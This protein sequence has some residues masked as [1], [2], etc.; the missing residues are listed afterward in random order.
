MNCS[1]HQPCRPPAP[2]MTWESALHLHLGAWGQPP[3][4]ESGCPSGCYLG[5]SRVGGTTFMLQDMEEGQEAAGCHKRRFSG[6]GGGSCGISCHAP[7]KATLRT[8]LRIT[9]LSITNKLGTLICYPQKFT[10][11]CFNLD[12]IVHIS[13]RVLKTLFDSV[14]FFENTWR[15]NEELLPSPSSLCSP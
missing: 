8:I 3:S 6:G 1:L 9:H 13:N 2:R 12:I 4:Q 10:K 11:A 15:L 5:V 7:R 14:I